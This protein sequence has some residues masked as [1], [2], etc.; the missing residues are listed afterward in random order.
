VASGA[1]AISGVGQGAYYTASAHNLQYLSGTVAGGLSVTS[2]NPAA[3]TS[4]AGQVR[5]DLIALAT[6]VIAEQ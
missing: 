4:L 2:T 3:L 1:E 5:A 6:K